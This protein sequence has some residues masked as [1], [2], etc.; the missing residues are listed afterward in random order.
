MPTFVHLAAEKDV[1]RIV[2]H[3]IRGRRTRIP[4]GKSH[5]EVPQ[6]VFCMPVMPNFHLTHQW[7]WELKRNGQRTMIGIYFR[8]PSE[9]PVWVGRYNQPHRNVSAGEAIKIIMELED[10]EG[11]EV[12]VPRTIIAKEIQKTRRLSQSVGWRYCPKSHMQKPTCACPYCLPPGSI[13]SKR[14]RHRIE[15]GQAKETSL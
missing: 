13:K 10:A 2:T 3:A 11:W 5:V 1:K 4:S 6:G 12:V 15:A 8:L 7:L 9:E 14:L